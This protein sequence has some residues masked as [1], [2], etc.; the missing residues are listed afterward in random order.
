MMHKVRTYPITRANV[1]LN[2]LAGSMWFSTLDLK[3]GYWQIEVDKNHRE[4][5]AFYT[6]KGLFQF[7]VG[8]V[9]PHNNPEAS[10][11]D[12]NGILMK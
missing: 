7:N 6:H 3:S 5:T 10:G 8:Y 4:K 12:T 1:T 11:Y 2:T 9:M